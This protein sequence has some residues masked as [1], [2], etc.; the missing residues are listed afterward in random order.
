M[1]VSHDEYGR[2]VHRSYNSCISSVQNPIETPLSS[3]CQLG[4]GV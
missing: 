4:L 3:S 1:M 2:V